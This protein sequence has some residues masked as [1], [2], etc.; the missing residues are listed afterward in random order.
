MGSGFYIVR[1]SKTIALVCAN[2]Q[3]TLDNCYIYDKI[4]DEI[5][6]QNVAIFSK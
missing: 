3:K 2:F 6:W 4:Y 5:G 1:R